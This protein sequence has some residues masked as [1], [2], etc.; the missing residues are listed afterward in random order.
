MKRLKRN[1]TSGFLFLAEMVHSLIPF[2]R[3]PFWSPERAKNPIDHEKQG[4]E[5]G[6]G[7]LSYFHLLVK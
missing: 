1:E 2:V 7:N 5:T 6:V 4:W 3:K